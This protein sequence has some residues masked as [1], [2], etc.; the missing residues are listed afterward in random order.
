ML[1]SPQSIRCLSMYTDILTPRQTD[2]WTARHVYR[3]TDRQ[4]HVRAQAL[5]HFLPW[6]F[7]GLSWDRDRFSYVPMDQFP[8]WLAGW[9]PRALGLSPYV[10]WL[11]KAV[12]SASLCHPRSVPF[13][14]SNFIHRPLAKHTFTK[15]YKSQSNRVI[16]MRFLRNIFCLVFVYCLRC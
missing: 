1:R 14:K 10:G 12:P 11:S 13:S 7:P 2:R 5:V 3:Q 9:L 4:T 6:Y 8:C 16:P 15:R